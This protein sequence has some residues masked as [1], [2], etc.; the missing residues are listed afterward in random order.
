MGHGLETHL[1]PH[2]GYH[3][4]VRAAQVVDRQAVGLEDDL[5]T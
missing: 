4:L 1:A 2:D 3:K 5:E